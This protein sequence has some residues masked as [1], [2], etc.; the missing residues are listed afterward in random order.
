MS[1]LREVL[2]IKHAKDREYLITYRVRLPILDW[3]FWRKMEYEDWQ[4]K[5]V[6]GFG[7]HWRYYPSADHP[8]DSVQDWLGDV[9]QAWLWEQEKNKK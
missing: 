8:P 6:R 7:R 9:L 4:T 3:R 5:T 1:V 2:E